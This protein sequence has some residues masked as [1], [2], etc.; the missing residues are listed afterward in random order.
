MYL[1]NTKICLT[2]LC[3]SGFELYSH[4]V[5]LIESVSCRLLQWMARMK[6]NSNFTKL[7]QP[8]Q[9]SM[10]C[11]QNSPKKLLWLL[12]SSEICLISSSQLYTQEHFVYVWRYYVK[13]SA[14]NWPKTA[15]SSWHG[16]FNTSPVSILNCS[17]VQFRQLVGKNKK[18]KHSQNSPNCYWERLM[19]VHEQAA[20]DDCQ[21]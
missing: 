21:K 4:W 2:M 15:I 12:I 9:V 20:L 19:M 5:P 6:M 14:Q 17:H 1:L 8:F 10:Q 16:P 11:L 3:F 13:T 18:I 7:G